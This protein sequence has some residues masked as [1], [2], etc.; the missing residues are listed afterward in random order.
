MG[1]TA[2]GARPQGGDSERDMKKFLIAGLG[3]TG[4]AYED[5]RHNIGF[6]VVD[7]LAREHGAEWATARLAAR[8][9]V[10]HK[11]RK[12]LLIKP[13]TYMNLSG[14][15][16]RYWMQQEG[17]PLENLLVVTDDIH[18]DF[19]CFRLRAKGSDGG[20][21]GLKS[22][23]SQLQ[24]PGYARF[25]FGVGRDFPPGGQVDYVLGK[26]TAE[27]REK[28]TERLKQSTAL[29][30]SFALAGLQHTM[31]AFNGNPACT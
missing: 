19:G 2:G 17:I 10:S 25:R 29:L 8:S 14:K 23:Q 15:A 31:N 1:C 27:E 28:L 24:T 11:G 4:A 6:Q 16:V 12:L 9:T 30:I 18:L 3:N 26:W 5:T 13:N 22:V 21:N 7:A 20:H